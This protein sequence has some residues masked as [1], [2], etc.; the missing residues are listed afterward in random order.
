MN[1]VRVRVSHVRL[2]PSAAFT[3]HT[4]KDTKMYG[5]K[6]IYLPV[7]LKCAQEFVLVTFHSYSALTE[8]TLQLSRYKR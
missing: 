7:T 3:Q 8:K 1:T 2:D 4:D 5:Y 6:D